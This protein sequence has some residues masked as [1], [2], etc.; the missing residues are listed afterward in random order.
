L[1]DREK[2]SLILAFFPFHADSHYRRGL[3]H[4]RHND[5]HEAL[6]DFSMAIALRPDHAEGHFPRG[7]IH[8]RQAQ[9]KKAVVD[10]TQTLELRPDHRS[11]Y[12]ERAFAHVGLGQ[13]PQASADFGQACRRQPK[14]WELWFG[15]GR[16]N[17]ELGRWPDAAACFSTALELKPDCPILW[18]ERG[19]ACNHMA[20]WKQAVADFSKA[21]E[22]EG[23]AV[24]FSFSRFL[25]TIKDPG[26]RQRLVSQVPSAMSIALRMDP[27]PAWIGRNIAYQKLGQRDKAREDFSK[28][29]EL[30]PARASATN[31]LA[32]FLATGPGAEFRDAKRAVQLAEQIV[33]QAPDTGAYWNTLGAAHYR[34]GNWKEAVAALEKSMRLRKGGDSFD[35]FF[36]AM[37]KWRLSQK[38]EA[39]QWYDQAVPWMEKNQPHHEE[40]QRFRAEAAALLRIGERKSNGHGP[41]RHSGPYRPYWVGF[42]NAALDAEPPKR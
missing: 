1:I 23:K 4:A 28:L 36:L 32:W 5:W 2:Y 16:A 37:A 29:R 31:S 15:R 25:A 17:V 26:E 3:A 10:F 40:L 33:K 13:W 38:E 7:L 8:A 39:R 34:A 27:T 35:W 42:I 11:A 30:S 12:A 24:S 9:F 6:A 22:L 19:Q 14:D 21:L 18:R 20:Q 41:N